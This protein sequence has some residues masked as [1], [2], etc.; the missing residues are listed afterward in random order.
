M[1]GLDKRAAEYDKAFKESLNKT[2]SVDQNIIEQ[3]ILKRELEQFIGD[4]C[5][6]V[7]TLCHNPT[8]EDGNTDWFNDTLPTVEAGQKR[9]KELLDQIVANEKA[10]YQ[11]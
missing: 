4:L 3:T 5:Y 8:H 10:K 11:Q 1:T 7:W 6:T 9:V 2:S